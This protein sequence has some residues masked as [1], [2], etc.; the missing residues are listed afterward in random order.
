LYLDFLLDTIEFRGCSHSESQIKKHLQILNAIICQGK[1]L[2]TLMP[3]LVD[4]LYGRLRDLLDLRYD[5]AAC[6]SLIY[7][8]EQSSIDP[9]M[10]ED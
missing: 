1:V 9:S 3:W 8:R 5:W 2:T 4:K 6:R 10:D 7:L